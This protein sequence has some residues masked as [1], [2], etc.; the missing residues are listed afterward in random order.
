MA[1]DILAKELRSDTYNLFS[2]SDEIEGKHKTNLAGKKKKE[3][4]KEKRQTNIKNECLL[5]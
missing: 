1:E 4:G 3:E 5:Y 2:I